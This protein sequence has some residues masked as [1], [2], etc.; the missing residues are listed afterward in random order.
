MNPAEHLLDLVNVD[1][2]TRSSSNDYDFLTAT[3][4]KIL[5]SWPSS[6]LANRL[7]NALSLLTP[8][9]DAKSSGPIFSTSVPKPG[10]L[11]QTA[12]LLRRS[13]IKSHR[14][15]VTYW[16]RVVM[17]LGLAILMGTVW[18]RLSDRQ[19]DIQGFVNAL[20]GRH[21]LNFFIL[22]IQILLMLSRKGENY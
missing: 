13:W 19:E 8:S 4:E 12:V 3:L 21:R 9:P 10:Y 2:S 22:Y 16:V 7:S 20:V 11:K 15:I 17:Y 5:S 6:V 1:F 18:L 14:D